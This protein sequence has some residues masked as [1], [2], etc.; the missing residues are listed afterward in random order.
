MATPQ[1]RLANALQTLHALQAKGQNIVRSEHLTRDERELLVGRGFL[2]PVIR[3]WYIP[4]SPDATDGETTAWYAAYWEFVREY[5]SDRFDEDWVLAPEPSLLLH[6]GQ[7]NVPRQLLVRAPS[8]RN[9]TTDFIFGTSIY[10]LRLKPPSGADVMML[11]GLR[12][13]R[14]EAALIAASPGVFQ[15]YP[16]EL[17]TVLAVQRDAS[18]LL[19][20]LLEGGNSVVAGRLAGAFRNI[21]RD[22]DADEIV[23][24][25]KAAGYKIRE[26]DPFRARIE[27]LVLGRD[28]SP[29]VQRIRLMWAQMRE[30]IPPLFPSPPARINHIDGYL[31]RLDDLYVTDAYHSLSIEGYRVSPDLIERVR[32]GTWDPD[33]DPQDRQHKDAMAARGYWEAFQVVKDSVHAVLLGE[34]PGAVADRDHGGWYRALFAPSVAAGLLK[35]ANLAGYRNHPVYIRGSAHTP[36][37]YEAVRDVMPV[38]FE[39]LASETDP[40]VRVVLGHF[41]FVYIHPYMDGNGRTGRFLMNV[42]MAAGGYP[43][44]VIP[45]TERK[46][47]MAA[48]ESASAGGDI[49]PFATFLAERVRARAPEAH[50]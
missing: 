41:V 31:Q 11:N 36:L 10:D 50:A 33:G 32:S 2:R 40:A 6:A 34:N 28:P 42:M 21:G 13:Y 8:A 22:R 43:W 5:L 44:T 37:P 9:Q 25:M 7:W 48:L 47:Y 49:K 26:D 38:L 35:P 16:T 12:V 29:Y 3:G 18:A 14:P 19:A 24:A 45:V 30:E 23:A 1:E 46:R 17:R 39:L 15:S 4:S 27:G 20:R